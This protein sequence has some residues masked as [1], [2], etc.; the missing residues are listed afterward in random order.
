M[1][2]S[3]T[4]IRLNL[5]LTRWI[6]SAFRSSIKI[7]IPLIRHRVSPEFIGLRFQESVGTESIELKVVSV[8]TGATFSGIT[9]D[10]VLYA[11]SFSHPLLVQVCCG[12]L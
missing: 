5:V 11:S 1:L 7:F 3:F 9:M 2:L 4:Y 8:R 12:L 6:F 10:Q